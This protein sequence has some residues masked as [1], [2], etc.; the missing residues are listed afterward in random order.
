MNTWVGRLVE[1]YS[2]QK[3][4]LV[5]YRQQ[6]DKNEQEQEHS[7]VGGMIQDMSFAL[8][9]MKRGRRPGNRRGIDRRSVYQRTALLDPDL[10]PALDIQP[11][12]RKLDDYERRKIVDILWTLSERERQCYL[13]HMSH[14]MSY[15][16]IS[17]ELKLSRR[18]VQQYVERAKAK[19][20][21]VAA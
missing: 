15:A 20:K 18:T 12:E 5:E 2:D 1:E 17:T 3:N 7:T 8:E 14:G 16:E 11:Q 19:I 21:N 10:F 9:W 6:L 13:L 4:Y